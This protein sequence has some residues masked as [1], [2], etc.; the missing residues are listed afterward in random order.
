M[1]G[2]S[3]FQDVVRPSPSRS[4]SYRFLQEQRHQYGTGAWHLLHTHDLIALFTGIGT[5][6]NKVASTMI[7]A[8]LLVSLGVFLPGYT[9]AEEKM[10]P[11]FSVFSPLP[12]QELNKLNQQAMAEAK[13]SRI[14]SNSVIGIHHVKLDAKKLFD[15]VFPKFTPA[16][17]SI[18]PLVEFILTKDASVF[19]VTDRVKAVDGSRTWVGHI[20]N[21]LRSSALFMANTKT[22]TISGEIR[23]DGIVYEIKPGKNDSYAIFAVDTRRLPPDHSSKGDRK[24]LA[25][26]APRELLTFTNGGGAPRKLSP[27]LTPG[28]SP[29]IDV[30]VLYTQAAIDADTSEDI[31]N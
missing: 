29:V 8:F 2:T 15:E 28:I 16:D 13:K 24:L 18:A 22:Q 12:T 26:R 14:R 27:V 5:T 20:Q 6:R 10:P 1:K 23:T 7:G 30:M 19:I 17:P 21:N 3:D 9:H 11:S 31:A 25:S 4:P